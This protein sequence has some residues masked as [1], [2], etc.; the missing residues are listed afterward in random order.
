MTGLLGPFARFVDIVRTALFGVA[1]LAAAACAA[2][3]AVRTRR[4]SPYGA[5]ARFVRAWVDP[6]LKPVERMVVRAGAAP[7]TVPWWGLV[8]LLVLGVLVLAILELLGGVLLRLAWGLEDPARL[9]MLLLSWAFALMR[10]ALIVRV[11]SSWLPI[12]PVS[13][14]IQWSVVLT[15]WGLRPL[16]RIVPPLGAIDVT[17][18]VA[19]FV[20]WLVQS[21]LHI[22]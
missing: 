2:A 11:V 14:W 1:V 4:M 22:P 21:V 5:I 13:R 6:A 16:R 8:F 15:E 3:W 7:A 18:I 12:S 19:Y 10:V 9:P 17:P 20:L